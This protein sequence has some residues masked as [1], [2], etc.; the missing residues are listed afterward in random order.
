M[1]IKWPKQG[2][3]KSLLH[4]FPKHVLRCTMNETAKSLEVN[5]SRGKSSAR[6]EVILNV[7]LIFAEIKSKKTLTKDWSRL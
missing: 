2:H 5:G 1:K 4:V 3:A 6:P 7:S